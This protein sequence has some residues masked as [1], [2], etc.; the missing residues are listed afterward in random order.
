MFFDVSLKR[1]IYF[2]Q[3]KFPGIGQCFW[4]TCDSSQRQVTFP[5]IFLCRKFMSCQSCLVFAEL[6][7]QRDVSTRLE[8]LEHW[9]CWPS[10]C[11]IA[12]ST[13]IV[14]S[15][16][17]VDAFGLFKRSSKIRQSDGG[18]LTVGQTKGPQKMPRPRPEKASCGTSKLLSP[19]AQRSKGIPKGYIM[20]HAGS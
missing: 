12:D 14:P 10:V 5:V 16:E 15:R 6:P 2:T 4:E 13:S 8:E 1:N 19:K 18:T 7:L 11:Q 20:N 3:S 17:F 9:K